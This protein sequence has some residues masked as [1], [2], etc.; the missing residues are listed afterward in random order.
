[1]RGVV[2]TLC[3]AIAVLVA[4]PSPASAHDVL[5]SAVPE[6]EQVL[7]SAP[8]EIVLTFS[9]KVMDVSTAVMVLDPEAET[10]ST[11]APLV[12]G[13]EVSVDVLDELPVGGYAVRWRVVSSDGHPISGTFTF[14]VGEGGPPPP[15]LDATPNQDSPVE[16]DAPAE[17]A[18]GAASPSAS[19]TPLRTTVL[20]L[21]GALGG[22][23]LYVTALRLR[24][25]GPLTGRSMNP[26]GPSEKETQ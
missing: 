21:I 24:R 17:N 7:R 15:P 4:A 12:D 25:T 16:E 6:D 14:H 1:M 18:A 13:H 20:A 26:T 11:S 2:R 3:V 22:V 5:I 10:V 23:L 9:G 19:S 8:E